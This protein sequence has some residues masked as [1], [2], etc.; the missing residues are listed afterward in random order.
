MPAFSITKD[1]PSHMK[2]KRSSSYKSAYIPQSRTQLLVPPVTMCFQN[3][4]YDCGHE[5]MNVLRCRNL[6]GFRGLLTRCCNLLRPNQADDLPC[7]HVPRVS[8]H[9]GHICHW[10]LIQRI[11]SLFRRQQRL[12]RALH[13][14]CSE[15]L[16]DDGPSKI[17]PPTSRPG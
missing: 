11:P 16:I 8:V 1:I 2:R 15:D 17:P 5:E 10:C 9:R 3:T 7:D 12:L 14:D 6:F 13:G 4:K